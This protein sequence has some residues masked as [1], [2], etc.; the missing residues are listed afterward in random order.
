VGGQCRGG[1]EMT[2]TTSRRCRRRHVGR[3]GEDGTASALR[4][5]SCGVIIRY[6]IPTMM[7]MMTMMMTMMM[8]MMM[9]EREAI[10]SSE[11]Q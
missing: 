4:P 5:T 10:P 8:M 2:T 1:G 11:R 9:M 6:V 3:E 7:M